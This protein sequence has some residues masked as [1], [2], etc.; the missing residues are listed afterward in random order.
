[1]TAYHT[2]ERYLT[3]SSLRFIFVH[4]SS[5]YLQSAVQITS[6]L[7]RTFHP[8]S[9]RNLFVLITATTWVK[10]DERFVLVKWSHGSA[11][12]D[13][14]IKPLADQNSWLLSK[15]KI[16]KL[17]WLICQPVQWL[18]DSSVSKDKS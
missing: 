10:E 6:H 17:D 9:Y 4:R 1:M 8:G 3:M 11:T 13:S 14:G 16:N 7:S 12:I 5:C 18:A 15:L 2:N